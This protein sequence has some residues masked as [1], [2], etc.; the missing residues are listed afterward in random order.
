MKKFGFIH[1]YWGSHE[2]IMISRFPLEVQDKPTYL[3]DTPTRNA[4][5]NH[6]EKNENI[7]QARFA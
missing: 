5:D 2:S 6:Q 1:I 4:H 7:C 3:A